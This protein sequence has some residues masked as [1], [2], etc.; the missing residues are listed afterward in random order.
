[1]PIGAVGPLKVSINPIL[2]VSA[3]IADWPKAISSAPASKNAVLMWIRSEC[4]LAE[5]R[6]RSQRDRHH[7][8]SDILN[9]KQV[10]GLFHRAFV[11]EVILIVLD[12]AS[13]G[14]ERERAIGILHHI[15]QIEILDR[16][17]VVAVFEGA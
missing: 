17:V 13:D 3:A 15:L 9:L 11:V 2:I 5:V 14:L 8:L 1:M 12:D 7:H 6:P 16:D 4:S 10:R